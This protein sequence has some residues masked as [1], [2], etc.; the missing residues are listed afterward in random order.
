MELDINNISENPEVYN[1]PYFTQIINNLS[2]GIWEYNVNTREAKWSAGFYKILGYAPGE[3]ECSYNFFFEHLLYQEDRDTLLQPK[4]SPLPIRLLTKNAGY[5]WYE[6]FIETH[7][8]SSPLRQGLLIN[9]HQHKLN[10]AIAEQN[11]RFLNETI[12]IAKIAGW[13]I[14]VNTMTLVLSKEAYNIYELQTGLELDLEE[15]ISFFEPSYRNVLNNAISN[16]IK[17]CR[18][19]DLELL[20]RST[21][22]KVSLLRCKGIALIDDQGKCT[23]IKGILQRVERSKDQET[24][25]QKANTLLE[26]QNNRLQNF[27]YIA[28]HNLRSHAG[29][30]KHMVDL[31]KEAELEDERADIFSHIQS[32]SKSLSSTVEHLEEVV[33]IQL[34]S[35][36]EKRLVNMESI[37]TNITN[38]LEHNIRNCGA[39][40]DSDFS[41]CPEVEYLPAYLE[42]IFQNLL[43]NAL[44]YCDTYRQLVIKCY[45]YKKDGHVYLVFED[46]GIG[47]DLEQHGDDI[48]GMYKTFHHNNDAR[49]IGLFITR[50]QIES[51]GG[52]ISIDSIVNVGTKFTIKLT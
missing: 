21:K 26:N 9:I 23:H 22:N 5:Q 50:N 41:K 8:E 42:S 12:T 1:S 11:N 43:T 20:F 36:K 34:E 49:G 16:A 38:L 4:T 6:V 2:T 13:Q 25:F 27:S 14:E 47:I 19:F 30:L 48:F 24:A 18:P 45:S 32:I 28:S 46:N 40:I 29:N 31:Y 52:S 3:I 35:T 33:N 17:Y 44:K 39:R 15:F 51:L 7:D 10:L 37:F